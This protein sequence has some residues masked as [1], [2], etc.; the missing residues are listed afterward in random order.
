[1][2]S[3]IVRYAAPLFIG[4]QLP[5]HSPPA[6]AGRA[7]VEFRITPPFHPTNGDP[8]TLGLPIGSYGFR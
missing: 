8:R 6:P 1:M 3:V 4:K 5:M 7:H 2:R